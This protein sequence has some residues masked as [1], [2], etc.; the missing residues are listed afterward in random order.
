[1]NKKLF[2]IYWKKIVV[3]LT[4]FSALVEC[5]LHLHVVH[6]NLSYIVYLPQSCP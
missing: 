3:Q 1:M 4:T 6:E 5:R 2:R